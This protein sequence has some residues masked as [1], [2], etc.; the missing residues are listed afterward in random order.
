MHVLTHS[1]GHEARGDAAGRTVTL[2][3]AT[4]R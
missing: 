4:G 3:G 2:P 1:A